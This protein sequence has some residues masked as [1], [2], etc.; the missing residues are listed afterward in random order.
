[1]FNQKEWGNKY[2]EFPKWSRR[3]C[4]TGLLSTSLKVCVWLD[5]LHLIRFQWISDCLSR[6]N[7]CPKV[8]WSYKVLF[9][10]SFK[11]YPNNPLDLA[12]SIYCKS[13]ASTQ[14]HFSA[15]NA[16]HYRICCICT[17]GQGF[18][19]LITVVSPVTAQPRSACSIPC[20]LQWKTINNG[21]PRYSFNSSPITKQW[22]EC[23]KYTPPKAS[24]AAIAHQNWWLE[25]CF[26]VELVCFRGHVH[27]RGVYIYRH[28]YFIKK[29]MSWWSWYMDSIT[30]ILWDTYQS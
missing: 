28:T 21:H 3:G 30:M 12:S 13:K 8:C 5:L 27:F 25:D 11:F 1:M 15:T 10:N 2:L 6:K 18:M 26:P 9:K 29:P 23:M 19:S 20:H 17:I 7:V 22:Y 16:E 14:R 24:I 4:Y